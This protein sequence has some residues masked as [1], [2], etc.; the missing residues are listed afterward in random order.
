M[1][2]FRAFLAVTHAADQA[3]PRLRRAVAFITSLDET[4]VAL[5]IS[6]G[7]NQTITKRMLHRLRDEIDPTIAAISSLLILCSLFL[8][9]AAGRRTRRGLNPA[10]SDARPR[11]ASLRQQPGGAACRDRRIPLPRVPAGRA[12][13][14]RRRGRPR[15]G[16]RL[17]VRYL[18]DQ[19]EYLG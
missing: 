6:G 18:I 7:D 10:P 16:S 4:V 9:L 2:R 12:A 11:A 13:R 15:H 14:R 5:F 19:R 17:T 8:V 1:N 3:E